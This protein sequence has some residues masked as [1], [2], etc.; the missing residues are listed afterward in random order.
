MMKPATF[1]PLTVRVRRMPKRING[2]G[3]RSSHATKAISSAADTAK[4]L[5]RLGR[6]PAVLAGLGDRVDQ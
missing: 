6:E 4:T 1:A 5:T 3:C 2:S